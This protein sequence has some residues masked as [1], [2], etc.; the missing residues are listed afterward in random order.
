MEDGVPIMVL[1][2][3]FLRTASMKILKMVGTVAASAILVVGLAPSASAGP[4]YTDYADKTNVSP[5]V[6]A[7]CATIYDGR[8]LAGVGCFR[9]HGDRVYV[10][11][12]RADGARVEVRGTVNIKGRPEFRCIG[13]GKA[14]GGWRVCDEWSKKMPEDRNFTFHAQLYDGNKL[15]ATSGIKILPIGGR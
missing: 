9:D 14:G 5:K 4:R 3:N 7:W 15:V 10:K 6:N 12:M 8:D 2:L 1:V 11:D 13:T